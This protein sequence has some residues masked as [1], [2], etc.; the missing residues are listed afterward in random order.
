[1]GFRFRRHVRLFPAVR[2]DFATGKLGTTIDGASTKGLV[3]LERLTN[4]ARTRRAAL[5]ADVRNANR[6]RLAAERKLRVAQFFVVRLFLQN[7]IEGLAR[8]AF[9]ANI[10]ANTAEDRLE[11]CAI[12]VSFAFNE[13][14]VE[15]H[16]VLRQ[17]FEALRTSVMLW[18]VTTPV[19]VNRY[20][21]RTTATH[22]LKR[23]P[24][25]FD[26]PPSKLIATD[27]DAIRFP[28]GQGS[29]IHLYPGFGM[30]RTD[31]QPVTLFEI[32]A[33]K[34][35]YANAD[36]I[37]ESAVPP[38]AEIIAQAWKH[39]NKD[40]SR[41]KRFNENY[42]IPLVRYGELSVSMGATP[43]VYQASHW[44]SARA[45]A[46]AIEDYQWALAGNPRNPLSA[47]TDAPVAPPDDPLPTFTPP[48]RPQNLALDWIVLGLLA[49]AAIPAALWL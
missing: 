29:D 10:A 41:D 2:L 49:A 31:N 34:V 48:V 40:G 37:E 44:Q 7:S 32:E 45:F 9:D 22:E 27:A 25:R 39:A 3:E 20:K 23:Q 33:L 12:T 46:N 13:E 35:E 16:T 4:E 38:D 36:F 19:E 18:I 28:V 43:T 47:D 24:I 26:V 1:M 17:S 15:K 6:T 21:D 8:A 11:A 14:T 30:L 42:E 5:A